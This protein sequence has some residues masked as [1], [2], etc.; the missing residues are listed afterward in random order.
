MRRRYRSTVIPVNTFTNHTPFKPLP[1][2][3]YFLSNWGDLP[4]SCCSL[5]TLT[6]TTTV[7]TQPIIRHSKLP[8]RLQWS[9]DLESYT[10]PR[11]RWWDEWAEPAN[12]PVKSKGVAHVTQE[13]QA[14][15][16]AGRVP[17]PRGLSPEEQ[18]E[19][20]EEE[21][22]HQQKAHHA[23]VSNEGEGKGTCW[24]LAWN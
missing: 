7:K 8:S 16:S 12:I 3:S 19:M 20:E 13:S 15:W 21:G 9:C 22:G 18:E 17:L 24:D 23:C 11:Q 5:I 4:C 10:I 2:L 1:I 14:V 6:I